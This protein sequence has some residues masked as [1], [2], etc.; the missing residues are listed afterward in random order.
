MKILSITISGFRNIYRQT[1][2]INNFTALVSLNNYGKSNLLEAIDFGFKF[3]TAPPEVKQ[4]MMSQAQNYPINKHIKSD[5]FEF[6]LQAVADNKF[7]VYYFAFSWK[8]K[9]IVAER[10]KLKTSNQARRLRTLIDRTQEKSLF[11]QSA[12]GRCDKKIEIQDNWLIINKLHLLGDWIF[13][14]I[15]KAISSLK[16]QYFPLTE[17]DKYFAFGQ[18]IHKTPEA[19]IKINLWSVAQYLYELKVKKPDDFLFFKDIIINLLPEIED[20]QPIEINLKTEKPQGLELPE[21]F[22]DIRV[23]FRNNTQDLSIKN[24]SYGTRRIFHILSV[25][26]RESQRNVFNVLMF[27]ELENSIHPA[28]MQSLLDVLFEFAENLQII[29]TSH[30]P[31]LIQFLDL[32]KIY[33]GIPNDKGLV[34]FAKVRKSRHNAIYKAAQRMEMNLGEF[35]FDKLISDDEEFWQENF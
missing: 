10:L 35:I 4:A 33:I 13:A 28:L 20:F 7:F 30:S 9:K 25:A 11:L 29:I 22:Y 6:E 1:L 21:K 18:I 27:E 8:T 26:M 15:A 12:G 24:L 14:D 17:I 31:H 34:R 16:A 5:L 2:E 32:D 23:K 3:I 19:E